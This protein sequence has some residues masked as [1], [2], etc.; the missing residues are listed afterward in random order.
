MQVS[1][2]TLQTHPWLGRPLHYHMIDHLVGSP[3][4]SWKRTQVSSLI[5]FYYP[6][7][8]HVPPLGFSG[9]FLL[10]VEDHVG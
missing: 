5:Y 8:T 10:A 4:P 6:L 2:S 7:I 3:S 1:G 9:Y